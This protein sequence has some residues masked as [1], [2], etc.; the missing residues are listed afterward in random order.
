[1]ACNNFESLGLWPL[2]LAIYSIKLC[3]FINVTCWPAA[4][5]YRAWTTI[6]LCCME[7]GR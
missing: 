3:S 4:S 7:S 2:L 5:D 6:T 1:M